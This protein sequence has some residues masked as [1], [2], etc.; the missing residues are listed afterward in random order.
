MGRREVS[1]S[2][3]ELGEVFHGHGAK[4]TT[5]DEVIDHE[6][7]GQISGDGGFEGELTIAVLDLLFQLCLQLWMDGDIHGHWLRVSSH[8]LSLP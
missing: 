6:S 1:C 2:W 3:D 4:L 8:F 7:N 5:S